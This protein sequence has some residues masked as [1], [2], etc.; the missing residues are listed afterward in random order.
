MEHNKTVRCWWLLLLVLLLL[1]LPALPGDQCRCIDFAPHV[2]LRSLPGSRWR[3]RVTRSPRTGAWIGLWG[4]LSGTSGEPGSHA[5]RHR[6]PLFRRYPHLP[7]TPPIHGNPSIH[8]SMSVPSI[9]RPW[10]GRLGWAWTLRVPSL[11]P[12]FE[13][14]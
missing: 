1:L 10:Q 9:S 8:H 3:L 2:P 7:S 12:L 11:C 13:F 6:T 14:A 5:P 4:D